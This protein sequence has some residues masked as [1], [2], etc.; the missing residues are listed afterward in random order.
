MVLAIIDFY[1]IGQVTKVLGLSGSQVFAR[2][3]QRDASELSS[4]NL[5]FFMIDYKLV[6]L[7]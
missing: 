2:R 4:T 1:P 7:E 3:K 5:G 6:S